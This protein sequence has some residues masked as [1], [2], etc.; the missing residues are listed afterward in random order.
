MIFGA[1]SLKATI[2][3]SVKVVDRTSV[4]KAESGQTRSTRSLGRRARHPADSESTRTREVIRAGTTTTRTRRS[5][6]I[7]ISDLGTPSSVAKRLGSS[8]LRV[9]I[10]T[11]SSLTSTSRSITIRWRTLTERWRTLPWS[12]CERYPHYQRSSVGC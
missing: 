3:I 6:S 2:P 5:T 12:G 8:G 11:L 9:R 10:Q 7:S 1:S 4:P